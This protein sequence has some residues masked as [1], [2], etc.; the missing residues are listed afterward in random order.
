VSVVAAPVPPALTGI[1][2]RI[3][4]AL[5][6]KSQV[7]LY[8][9][10]G[11]GKTHHA[12]EASQE[13]ASRSFFGKSWSDL[14]D[15]DKH[16]LRDPGPGGLGAIETCCFHPAFGYEDFLE[17][18]RPTAEQGGLSFA[19]RD[20]VFKRLCLRAANEPERQYFLLIDEINRGDVP[21]IFGELLT[22]LERS[23]RGRPIT[24]P[25]SGDTFVVP[26]NVFVIATM[27]TA[28]RSI[29]L[30]DAALRRRFAFIELMPQGEAIGTANVRG[31][32]LGPWLDSLNARVRKHVGRDARNLQVG[33]TY[34]LDGGVPV[35]D[36]AKLR[37]ALRDEI[38][39]LLEEYCYDRPDALVEVV[40]DALY[41]RERRRFRDELLDGSN[42]EG[43]VQALLKP[44][45]GIVTTRA[46]IDAGELEDDSEPPDPADP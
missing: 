17:G 39:P 15:T 38:F 8:G 33:H 12:E 6:R 20:G 37:V 2:G 26:A 34:L 9:P 4:G 5:R 24:L 28:D 31:V 40:G 19:R 44:D 46:A 41:D 11:T 7:I 16:R 30:L 22:V 45:P 27:N 18:Y 3:E 25:V 10:P 13:L 1:V 14:S 23:R 32:P 21:R 43:L 36:F 35:R 42:D 29:A